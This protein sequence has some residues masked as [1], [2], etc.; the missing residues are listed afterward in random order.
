MFN[1]LRDWTRQRVM[2]AIEREY[3]AYGQEVA[4]YLEIPLP[5]VR[6]YWEDVSKP[7]TLGLQHCE[8]PS[9][10]L[11]YDTEW[12]A[13]YARYHTDV[14]CPIRVDW[15]E[16]HDTIAHELRHAWQYQQ[17]RWTAGIFFGFVDK[18][19]IE[20]DA[21]T[22]ARDL[23]ARSYQGNQAVPF[24]V[25]AHYG[26]MPYELGNGLYHEC[27]ASMRVSM[28]TGGAVL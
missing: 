19:D 17:L 6:V 2:R 5:S 21:I 27:R 14:L 20:L 8:S 15:V 13:L 22:F 28:R 10:Q 4:D 12:I 7:Y 25:C 18:D 23:R 1:L 9:G 24:E 11:H 3:Y 16:V 26:R